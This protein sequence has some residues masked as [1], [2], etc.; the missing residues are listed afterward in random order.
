MK[1]VL[2]LIFHFLFSPKTH[3]KI[4]MHLEFTSNSIAMYKDVKPYTPAGFE[5]AIFV[6]NGVSP[7]PGT[8]CRRWCARTRGRRCCPSEHGTARART[9]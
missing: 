8:T 9:R 1:G 4:T 7:L 2:C 6:C 3:I 5:P